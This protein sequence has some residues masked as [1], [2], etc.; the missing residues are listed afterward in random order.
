MLAAAWARM[1]MPL[2][3]CRLWRPAWTHRKRTRLAR[4]PVVIKGFGKE[5][6]ERVWREFQCKSVKWTQR[7]KADWWAR[8]RGEAGGRAGPHTRFR[9]DFKNNTTKP[10]KPTKSSRLRALQCVG[11]RLFKPCKGCSSNDK[12]NKRQRRARPVVPHPSQTSR[13]SKSN[14]HRHWRGPYT[15]LRLSPLFYVLTPLPSWHSGPAKQ[16]RAPLWLGCLDLF[17]MCACLV[18][19]KQN[20][21]EASR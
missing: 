5:G 20:T 12:Q 3:G 17:C 9:L 6:G 1:M 16:C 2:G 14:T 10:A 8:R 7:N 21:H 4:H 13:S 15:V 18:L 11:K 19:R